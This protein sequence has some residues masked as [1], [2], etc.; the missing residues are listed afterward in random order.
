M[1]KPASKTVEGIVRVMRQTPALPLRCKF[2][3]LHVKASHLQSIS[4]ARLFAWTN[5]PLPNLG[6]YYSGRH[7]P[8]LLRILP[9]NEPVL[10]TKDACWLDAL[11]VYSSACKISGTCLA[12]DRQKRYELPIPP[13]YHALRSPRIEGSVSLSFELNYDKRG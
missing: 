3:M 8:I 7:V 6:V 2:G 4:S 10:S 13:P 11:G 9:F 1:T 12:M 5:S